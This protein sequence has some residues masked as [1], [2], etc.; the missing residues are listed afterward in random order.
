[1]LIRESNTSRA[2]PGL[3]LAVHHTGVASLQ[4]VLLSDQGVIPSDLVQTGGLFFQ[5]LYDLA[6]SIT[7]LLGLENA[8]SA[9]SHSRG[10]AKS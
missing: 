9:H 2:V 3:H 1:M 6:A 10:R 8:F 7:P 5:V 4:G